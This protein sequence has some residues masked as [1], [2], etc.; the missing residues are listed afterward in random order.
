MKIRK[1]NIEEDDDLE[2]IE[3]EDLEALNNGGYH[4]ED[5]LEEFLAQDIIDT[6][7]DFN[8]MGS[9]TKKKFIMHKQIQ[10]MITTDLENKVEASKSNARYTFTSKEKYNTYMFGDNRNG[11]C[12]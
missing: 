8:K 11:K 3:E 12:G 10:R 5:E 6:R 2:G 1:F 4:S 7:V 9:D